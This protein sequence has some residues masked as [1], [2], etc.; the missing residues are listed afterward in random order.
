MTLKDGSI[1]QE[2]LTENVGSNRGKLIPTDIGLVVND[3]LMEYFPEIMD[4]NFTAN[5]EK[6]LD[7]VAEGKENWTKMISH[8]YQD[9][10]PQV[11]RTLNEKSEHRVGERELGTDPV[12]GKPV[13]VKIGR[14]G[15]VVQIGLPSDDEKPRFANLAKGQSIE[16]ITLDEALELFKL[17]RTLGEYEE[18]VVK[19]NVG[20]FGPYVQLGKLFVSIPKD[21]DPMSITLERAIELI[22]EKRLK[23]E[24]SHLKRFDEEPELEVRAG[25]W[26]PYISYQGKNY[27][28]PKS[29]VDRATELTLEECKKIIAAEPKK[30]SS[31]SRAKTT[32][33]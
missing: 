16:T 11:E 29:E 18:Q 20:R 17:P 33:K 7:E 8:F 28:I 10:E 26:G 2:M 5:V 3:F 15:P 32:K 1:T 27:K 31:R 22:K 12:S 13:S 25:R 30:T 4:Y 21:E 24:K 9:F 6:Q 14:F 23:E 19:A